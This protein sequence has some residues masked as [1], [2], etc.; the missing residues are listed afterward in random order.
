MRVILKDILKD[1]SYTDGGY[2]L[3]TIAKDAIIKGDVVILDMQD[4]PSIPTLFMN[5]SFGD[6]MTN[7]G[8]EKTKRLFLFNNINKALFERIQTYFNKYESLL[9]AT[10]ET[11]S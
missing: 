3:Y 1:K 6:L 8:I 7:F 2:D 4:V 5:T 9:N 11:I 10:T